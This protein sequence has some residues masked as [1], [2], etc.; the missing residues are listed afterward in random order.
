VATGSHGK[1]FRVEV[2]LR[3]RQW[4]STIASASLFF[5]FL[6][7]AGAEAQLTS[8]IAGQADA[9]S[10]VHGLVL[11]R[12]THEPIGRALVFS[13]DQR[14]ATLTD[15][16]GRFEFKFPPRAP[17]PKDDLTAITDPDALRN[18]YRARQIQ[19]LQN[20]RPETFLARKP[21]FLQNESKAGRAA[22][23]TEILIYL[24]PES[25][26]VGHVHLPGS[27]GDM[28]IR[29]ELYRREIREGQEHWE[30]VRTFTTWADGEFRF[31][32]LA[33]GV[34]KLNTG[35]QFDRDPLN[36]VPGG[37]L[38]GFPPIFY[39]GASDFSAAGPI[40]L[41]VGM[42]FQATLSPVR[43][44]YYPVKIPVRNAA[45][46]QSILVRIYPLGHP[47]PG[48][49]LGYNSAEQLIQGTLPD[50][51]YT[52]EA[53]ARGP[54][55]STGFLN[56]SVRG[57]PSEGPALSLIPNTSLTATVKEEFNSVQAGSG[58]MNTAP[59]DGGSNFF[60][61][62][63]ADVQVTMMPVGEFG[64]GETP[65]SQPIE[66]SQDN[67][68]LIPNVRPGRY[69]VRV[70]TPI[71]FAAS[72]VSGGT[73]LL[74][75]PLVVGLGGSSSPIEITLRDDGAQVDGKTE[76]DGKAEAPAACHVYFLPVSEGSGQFREANSTQEGSFYLAQLPPGTYRVLAFDSPQNDLA[77]ADAEAMRK[78]ESKGQVL[79]VDAGQK[80]H[81][82]LKI[83]PGGD[84][85]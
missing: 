72:V 47:G 51:N 34:Y 65:V 26:I 16:L 17:E 15:D 12:V 52:V 69:R 53:D 38:F 79:H 21:G 54:S 45:A 35:E 42:T 63:R 8:G 73:D 28:R 18:A 43:H 39:P 20:T 3:P 10:S 68:V 82:R 40:E 84:S 85:Q 76:V 59:V 64:S 78:L 5:W 49:S 19:M 25:L 62:R 30:Q 37:Q 50:G 55:S 46:D 75:Q 83:I 44:A 29:A 74:R 70:A 81:M 24:D 48:Y 60:P 22:N 31:S 27:E 9:P 41:G 32:E 13:P 61:Q 67:A 2:P 11:N 1:H 71:G 7:A 56:F 14:Y 6:L 33:A 4:P 36:F 66:N 77:Y 80:E 58:V 57:G 23:Q